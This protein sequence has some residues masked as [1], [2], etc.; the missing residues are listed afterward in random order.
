[1]QLPCR[2]SR[3]CL[4]GCGLSECIA[5]QGRAS[6]TQRCQPR[7]FSYINPMVAAVVVRFPSVWLPVEH[8]ALDRHFGRGGCSLIEKAELSQSRPFET[9]PSPW[10]VVPAWPYIAVTRY[11]HKSSR[12]RETVGNAGTICLHPYCPISPVRYAR[13]DDGV[14]S[15]ASQ[16]L[17]LPRLSLD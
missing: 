16:P 7:Q 11:C 3:L 13:V 12:V 10:H 15:S 8:Q 1:M 6:D 9:P 5:P 17:E 4:Y 2:I 14:V